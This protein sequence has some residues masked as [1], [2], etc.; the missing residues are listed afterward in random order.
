MTPGN[1]PMP[2]ELIEYWDRRVL[3]DL[4][5]RRQKEILWRVNKALVFNNGAG[6][7]EGNL[8]ADFTEA[9]TNRLIGR[10]FDV[11]VQADDPDYDEQ[12]RNAEVAANAVSRIAG[13]ED[14]V[15][16]AITHATWAPFGVLEVGHPLD[17]HSM[18]PLR[19]RITTGVSQL[20]DAVQDEWV[21]VDP[22]ALLPMGLDP[23]A[24]PALETNLENITTDTAPTPV[25][26]PGFGYPWIEAIDPRYIVI[27]ENS[28]R[29]S[30]LPYVAR[31]RFLTAQEIKVMHGV[32][33]SDSSINSEL[34]DL[35]QEL[36]SD[37]EWKHFPNMI[38]VVDLYIRRDRNNPHFNS[39]YVS[40]V[41]GRPDIVILS[42]PNPFGGMIPF[43]FVR[44]KKRGKMY[45]TT[46]A[47]ELSAVADSYHLALRGI[48]N[49]LKD[50]V[51]R[52]LLISN[53]TGISDD[54]ES[55][56]RNPNFR[57]TVRVNDVNGIKRLFSDTRF[58]N[59][60]FRAAMF[61]KAAGQ[62]RVGSSDIDRGVPIKNITAKQTEA[63]L[64]ATGVNIDSMAGIVS[65][66][67]SQAVHKLMHLVG[68]YSMSGR[69]RKFNYGPRVAAYSTGTHDFTTSLVYKIKIEPVEAASDN[70]E[71]LVWV[72]FVNLL[73]NV[74]F[75][76]Q[77]FDPLF[78]AKKLAK[79]F[80]ISMRAI[81]P[82]PQGGAGSA[83]PFGENPLSP[84]MNGASG[85]APGAPGI[86]GAR[87]A[88]V[89]QHP[90]RLTGSRG[91]STANALAG[92]RRTG[93][94]LG[95]RR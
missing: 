46:L 57:G 14:E 17:R 11:D 71:K 50:M 45:G 28:M 92:L 38:C 81:K 35:Y 56:I 3:D 10:D 79:V 54:D 75:I 13:F 41:L 61:L 36:E 59:D 24:I 85:G 84:Q 31:L 7:R 62:A 1:S 12:A 58:D 49:D 25:F 91:A 77:L 42:G 87:E 44:L 43:V 65:E 47:E 78:I 48:K 4:R 2:L 15:R 53:G 34:Q 88:V 18:D 86:D 94:G 93:S 22:S 23:E 66:A 67:A 16:E 83:S 29:P 52:T 89:G 63:I 26:D 8:A 76:T 27:P 20:T 64:D 60:L 33:L 82:P 90:E 30:R 9:V 21:E 74:P 69:G 5:A 51:N 37:G 68:L 55:N 32:D 72:Q 6:F 95:E 39:W 40:Y 70:E 73:Q 80:D 19:G